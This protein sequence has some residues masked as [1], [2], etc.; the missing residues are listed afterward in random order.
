MITAR[1]TPA[2]VYP[3]PRL[4]RRAYGKRRVDISDISERDAYRPVGS[5]A[6]RP[7]TGVGET[8]TFGPVAQIYIAVSSTLSGMFRAPETGGRGGVG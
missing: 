6:V 5:M 8:L 7:G 1:L 4:S 2:P 3:T